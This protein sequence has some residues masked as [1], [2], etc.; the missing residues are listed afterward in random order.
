[1]ME[2][3]PWGGKRYFHRGE[4]DRDF[5]RWGPS[6]WNMIKISTEVDDTP[7]PQFP[8][9]SVRWLIKFSRPKSHDFFDVHGGV[10]SVNVFP[11]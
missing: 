4:R 9:R 2:G 7:K 5:Y 6:P 11:S 8:P 10:Y 1:M 3:G